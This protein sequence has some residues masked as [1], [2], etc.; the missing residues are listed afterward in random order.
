MFY[1]V[2]KT[3]DG[4]SAGPNLF[5]L[6]PTWL[7]STPISNS[8]WSR[9]AYAGRTEGERN[10]ERKT[11]FH[12]TLIIKRRTSHVLRLVS[13]ITA[14]PAILVSAARGGNLHKP[15]FTS[16]LSPAVWTVCREKKKPWLVI[17]PEVIKASIHVL[18][19]YP[20]I[21]SEPGQC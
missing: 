21:N 3:V 6:L 14:N 18:K 20:V 2:F 1:N 13:Y 12:Q 15:I 19:I 16:H 5:C 10:K 9:M 17:I 7:N 11:S 4:S 8:G